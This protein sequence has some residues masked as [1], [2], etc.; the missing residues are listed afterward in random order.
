M[1]REEV[2][3]KLLHHLSHPGADNG[4][5]HEIY[6][7]DAVLE[8]PQSGERFR[9]SGSGGG[10][11]VLLSARRVGSTGKAYGLDMTD[12]MLDLACRNPREAGVDKRLVPQRRDRASPRSPMTPWT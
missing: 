4:K 10:I 3:D 5:A 9:G 7:D 11:D 6:H 8:F 1:R 12:E 2:H